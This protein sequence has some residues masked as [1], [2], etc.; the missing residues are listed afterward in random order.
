MCWPPGTGPVFGE[1]I[2]QPLPDV[3][4]S[5]T[6]CTIAVAR[7]HAGDRHRP[8]LAGADL[9]EAEVDAGVDPPGGG[10]HGEQPPDGV[11]V[12]VNHP[13]TSARRPRHRSSVS[14]DTF[15][16]LPVRAMTSLLRMSPA[17][18]VHV[19]GARPA[20][21]AGHATTDPPTAAHAVTDEATATEPVGRHAGAP[22]D[23]DV[24]P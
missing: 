11:A 15:P 1:A 16:P 12:E 2:S 23:L 18:D 22:R 7:R 24:D 13:A 19:G 20:R 9:A 3:P 10:E 21:P 6:F 5:V 8:L 14:I 17:R 4:T